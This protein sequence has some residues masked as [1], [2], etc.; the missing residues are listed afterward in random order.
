MATYALIPAAGR[1]T[2]IARSDVGDSVPKQY[3]PIAGRAM[4]WHAVRAVCVAPVETV[5]VVLAPRDDAFARLDWSEFGGRVEPLYCGGATRAESVRN[6]LIAA[7]AAVDA[8]DWMLVHDAA[9][10]CL[11]RADLERLIA[12]C[13]GDAIG[14]LLALPIADTVKRAA[15]DEAG[16]V[17]V[18]ATEDRALL[19]LAQTPQMFRAGLLA[20]AL[21]CAERERFT[22]EAAAIERLGLRPRLVAGSRE[23]LKVTYPEDFAIAEAILARRAGAQ[24]R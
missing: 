12:E 19:W 21:A 4:L 10:P 15:K 7:M 5:F 14:G 6:G 8:D 3:R 2:R 22:D 24:A 16:A 9:R 17:R 13:E 20:E 11:A 1:G 23:N 18:A